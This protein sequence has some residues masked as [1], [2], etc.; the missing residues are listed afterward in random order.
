MGI[1]SPYLATTG[2]SFSHRDS[3]TFWP[4]GRREN[5]FQRKYL[6]HWPKGTKRESLLCTSVKACVLAAFQSPA[7]RH[8]R[9]RTRKQL[10]Q[11][12]LFVVLAAHLCL[13]EVA[14]VKRTMPM[15]GMGE[16]GE[17]IDPED[18]IPATQQP[19]NAVQSLIS[20][21]LGKVCATISFAIA[22][23]ENVHMCHGHA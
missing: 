4:Q 11:W 14:A 6:V 8:M 12:S 5:R 7:A 17:E 21:L 18:D 13:R 16:D 3:K 20:G 15:I 10:R 23:R 19:R 1:I 2:L 22:C 9:S